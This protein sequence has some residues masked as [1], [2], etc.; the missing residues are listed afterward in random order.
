MEMPFYGYRSSRMTIH[1]A[2]DPPPISTR[3]MD[4]H[5]W[6][7]DGEGEQFHGATASE[8]LRELAD[9]LEARA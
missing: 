3:D 5:A 1:V 2:Y 8:A 9:A 7:D 6:D 4:W